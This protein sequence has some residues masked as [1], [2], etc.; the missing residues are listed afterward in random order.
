M[1]RN[2]DLAVAGLGAAAEQKLRTLR[3]RS[4]LTIAGAARPGMAAGG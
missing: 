3:Y 4:V 1:H 2:M